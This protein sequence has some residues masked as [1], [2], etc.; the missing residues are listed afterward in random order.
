MAWSETTETQNEMVV[1]L[2]SNQGFRKFLSICGHLDCWCFLK[3]W[4]LNWAPPCWK[5]LEL[6]KTDVKQ[7]PEELEDLKEADAK[8]EADKIREKDVEQRKNFGEV[9]MD[10]EDA[11]SDNFFERQRT[12]LENT[13]MWKRW[14]ITENQ[15]QQE[16]QT[17]TKRKQ[18]E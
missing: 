5:S 14:T 6:R 13:G 11:G 16:S 1:V 18:T 15:Q 2:Q 10:V 4:F 8:A 7:Q 12:E 9:D 17:L 3:W